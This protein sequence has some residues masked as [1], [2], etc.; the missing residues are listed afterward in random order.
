MPKEEKP[1]AKITLTEFIND[2]HKLLTIFGV[3]I[4]LTVF[5]GNIE[6]KV[7][8]HFQSFIFLFGA[9]LILIEIW[10]PKPSRSMTWRLSLFYH[11]ILGSGIVAMGVYCLLGFPKIW[12]HIVT[13]FLSILMCYIVGKVIISIEGKLKFF[14]P[15]FSWI[16]KH[17]KRRVLI[18]LHNL[19]IFFLVFPPC[20]YLAQ[21]ISRPINKPVDSMLEN[22]ISP[23]VE[24]SFKDPY[25]GMEFFFIKGGCFEMGDTFGDGESDEKPVHEVCIDD[26][27]LG[28]YEVTQ[29]QWEKV[30]DNNPSY[31][32]GRD[33][34]IEQ[35]SWDNVKQYIDRL[36]SQ[37]GRK[38]RLPTEA[39]WEY[40]ARS[41][42]K[43][44]KFSGTSQEADLV[45]YAWY[46]SNSGS[47]THPVGQEK[48][49]GLGLYDM[50][51]NVWEWCAD[52]YDE[53]YYKNSRKNNPRGPNGGGYRVL[54]GGSFATSPKLV[55]V[56]TRLRDIPENRYN[57]SFGFRLGF[58][59]R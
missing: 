9:F 32:E 42:G 49:N 55:R 24:N 45:Q 25:T 44:E 27:Y 33:N 2:K 34:P 3:F 23:E 20:Y 4:A 19:I 15:V 57:I 53:Y 14:N 17:K 13:Y 10:V 59:A 7:L 50:S 40:A 21:Y 28:K 58:S 51:G 37:G 30:M 52:W 35:V 48:S 11:Y 31:F 46:G 54:R 36:N 8:G 43:K 56:T 38:Y 29:A 1:V 16:A 39:E 12:H 26:F 22:A 41:G 47:E 5:S 6:V 18:R